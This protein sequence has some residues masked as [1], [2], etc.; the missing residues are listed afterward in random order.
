MDSLSGVL[1]K[2]IKMLITKNMF[3]KSP[4]ELKVF[5]KENNIKLLKLLKYLR[6]R[7]DKKIQKETVPK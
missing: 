3:R 6:K 4:G 5:I 2:I 1:W 7:N